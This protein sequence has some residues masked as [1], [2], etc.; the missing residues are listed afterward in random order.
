MLNLNSFFSKMFQIPSRL[1]GGNKDQHRIIEY[2]DYMK[3]ILTNS[4]IS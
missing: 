4:S 3:D 1:K 2:Y